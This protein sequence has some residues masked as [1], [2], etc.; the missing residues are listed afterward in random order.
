MSE[1]FA[2]H[3]NFDQFYT[4]LAKFKT[5]LFPQTNFLEKQKGNWKSFKNKFYKLSNLGE[6]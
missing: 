2:D 5:F 6:I 1:I 3:S 4:N